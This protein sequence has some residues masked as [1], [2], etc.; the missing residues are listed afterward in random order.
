MAKNGRF[1]IDIEI[2][3]TNY[4]EYADLILSK[5]SWGAEFKRINNF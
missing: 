3:G 4:N 2:N 1:N 5:F